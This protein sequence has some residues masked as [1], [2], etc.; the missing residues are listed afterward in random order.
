MQTSAPALRISASSHSTN[1][2]L[3]TATGQVTIDDQRLRD[4][5]LSESGGLTYAGPVVAHLNGNGEIV[6]I[7]VRQGVYSFDGTLDIRYATPGDTFSWSSNTITEDALAG[8]G[9]DLFVNGNAIDAFWV[10][11]DA[12]TIRTAHS[13][14]GGHT[15]GASSTVAVLSSQGL[16]VTAQLCCPMANVLVF[17]DS[18]VGQD[19]QHL[20]MTGLYLTVKVGGVWN[21]PTLWDLGGATPGRGSECGP[22]QWGYVPE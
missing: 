5:S 18:T 15:W 12:I 10:D 16:G 1:P 22:A 21:T 17:S 3:P 14:D 9:V 19:E 20:A 11:N 4:W 13:A 6:R 2:I 8:G 7:R